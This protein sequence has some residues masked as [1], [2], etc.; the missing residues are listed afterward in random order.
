MLRYTNPLK[1]NVFSAIS[2][3]PCIKDESDTPLINSYQINKKL[4]F[5]DN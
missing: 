2:V 5:S 3:Q 1:V 4:P